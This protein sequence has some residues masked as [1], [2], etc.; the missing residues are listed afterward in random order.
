M[1][2]VIPWYKSQIIWLQIVS[3]LYAVLRMLNLDI[4][5]D[6]LSQGQLVDGIVLVVNIATAFYRKT[7][8]KK[9]VPTTVYKAMQGPAR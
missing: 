1:N 2:D 5:P 4:L 9:I 7:A 6:D 3:G 8:Q